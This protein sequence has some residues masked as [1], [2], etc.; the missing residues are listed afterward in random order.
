M[1]Y[2]RRKRP[3]HLQHV[4]MHIYV[5]VALN[6]QT[7]FN[8]FFC[9]GVGDFLSILSEIERNYLFVHSFL[10]DKPE[11]DAKRRL[12]DD[13]DGSSNGDGMPGIN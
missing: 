7:V 5:R 13:R 2:E 11:P 9:S 4:R 3:Q 10:P 12:D 1:Q 6:C 8:Y